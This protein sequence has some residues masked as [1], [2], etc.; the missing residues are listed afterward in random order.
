MIYYNWST[1]NSID[2]N[3]Y[4]EITITPDSGYNLNI[5]DINFGERRSSTGIR[6][7]EVRW[8]IDNFTSSI[9]IADVIYLIIKVKEPVI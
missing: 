6:N 7:Y 4:F 2:L 9:T 8:S 1:N 3:K 5:S